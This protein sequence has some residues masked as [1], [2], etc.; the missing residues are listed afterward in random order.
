MF[1]GF[2]DGIHST[3]AKEIVMSDGL[4]WPAGEVLM[5]QS[6]VLALLKISRSNWCDGVRNKVYPQ[7]VRIGTKTVRWYTRE[8]YEYLNRKRGDPDAPTV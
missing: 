6:E 8:I 2:C 5:K 4:S 1:P 3:R 7:P